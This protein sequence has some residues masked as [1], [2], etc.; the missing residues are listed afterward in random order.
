MSSISPPTGSGTRVRCAF[1]TGFLM[2]VDEFNRAIIKLDNGNEIKVDLA[3]IERLDDSKVTEGATIVTTT[4]TT[5]SGSS[6]SSGTTTITT[7][8]SNTTKKP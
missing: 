8:S 6:G 4:T 3:E 7:K 5:T 2:N 1:G